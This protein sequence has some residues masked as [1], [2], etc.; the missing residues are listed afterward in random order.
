[1]FAG[2]M[3]AAGQDP[4]RPIKANQ[5]DAYGNERLLAFSHGG[6]GHR[7]RR[8]GNAQDDAGILHREK[9]LGHDH[10]HI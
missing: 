5:T 8:L 2:T 6:E 7:L 3:P 10:I 9:A 4:S 1:M